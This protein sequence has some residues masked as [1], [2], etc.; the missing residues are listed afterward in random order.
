LAA[1][2]ESYAYVCRITTEEVAIDRPVEI[3]TPR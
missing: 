2:V 3:V 1:G